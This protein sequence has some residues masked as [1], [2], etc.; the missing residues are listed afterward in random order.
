MLATRYLHILK[1]LE[2]FDKIYLHRKW[3]I[4]K[5]RKKG[6]GAPERGVHPPKKP[7]NSRILG[8]KS[9]VFLT[10]Y[11]KLRAK[12]GGGGGVDAGL[13]PPLNPPL[14]YLVFQKSDRKFSLQK[15]NTNQQI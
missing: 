4:Q 9:K 7:K 15:K 14:I 11:D 10:F 13:L 12:K 2:L 8:L 6:G 3:W 5:F 1:L